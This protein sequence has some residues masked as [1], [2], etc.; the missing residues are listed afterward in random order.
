MC[1]YVFV[2]VIVC[3]CVCVCLLVCICACLC[4]YSGCCSALSV[5]SAAGFFVDWWLFVSGCRLCVVV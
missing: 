3:V 2:Y 4:L 5:L 1:V